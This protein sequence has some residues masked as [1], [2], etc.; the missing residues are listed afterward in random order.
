MK[1]EE[2]TTLLETQFAS[3]PLPPEQTRALRQHMTECERCAQQYARLHRLEQLM[4]GRTTPRGQVDRMLAMTD[5]VLDDLDVPPKVKSPRR[6]WWSAGPV[7]AM[8]AAVLLLVDAKGTLLGLTP[9]GNEIDTRS[10]VSVYAK[11]PGSR[12]IRLEP[13]ERLPADAGL[14]FD[15]TNLDDSDARY[16]LIAG[17][18]SAGRVHWYH[19]AFRSEADDPRSVAIEAGVDKQLLD[20]V[21]YAD[22]AE[23]A[24]EVCAAFTKAPLRVRD[25]DPVV[26]RGGAWPKAKRLDCRRFEVVK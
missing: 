26:E 23:G 24:L 13:G 22:H 1:H 10:W 25:I 4:D 6:W 17:R 21:L 19:P 9:R 7:L 15:Y 5:A 20:E 3:G 2:A 11:P 18:D 8:A 14:I 16:M 12:A